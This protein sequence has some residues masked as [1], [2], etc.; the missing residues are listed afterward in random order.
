[1]NFEFFFLLVYMSI[2]SFA[3]AF[4]GYYFVVRVLGKDGMASRIAQIILV[5]LLVIAYDMFAFYVEDSWRYFVLSIPLAAVVGLALY[6]YFF[7]GG[8]AAGFLK[9]PKEAAKAMEAPA[10]KVSKKSERIHAARA[11]RGR[12]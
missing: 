11:K 9:A 8:D 6:G 2:V 5:P 10:K 4:I 3:L 7:R 12:E 1:M